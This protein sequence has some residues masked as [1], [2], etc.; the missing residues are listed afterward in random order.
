M[1]NV[2][3]P[4]A[5]LE[6]IN[7]LVEMLEKEKIIWHVITDLDLEQ[8]PKFQKEWIRHY[9]CPNIQGTFYE[10]C[11]NSINWWI[12]NHKPLNDEM[13]CILNDDDGYQP[14]FFE[15]LRNFVKELDS[16]NM[17]RDVIMVSMERGHQIPPVHQTGIQRQHPTAKLWA[18]P[19]NMR[20]SGV[21][22]EQII[23]SGKILQKYKIPL[24]HDGDGK[25]ITAIVR[26][27]SPVYAPHINVWFNYFEPGRWNK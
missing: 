2:I 1:F 27:H 26:D 15:K 5:R 21:G 22:V 18:K 25:W 8:Q 6:N 19:E 7:N 3:T 11:N 23:L 12:E 16:K 9:I 13:Y 10:K 17:N 20:P 14:N 24:E 4:L